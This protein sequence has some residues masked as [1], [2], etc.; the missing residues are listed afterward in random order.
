MGIVKSNIPQLILNNITGKVGGIVIRRRYGKTIIS[1]LPIS[2]KKSNSES[3]I[4]NRKR[5]AAISNISTELNKVPEFKELWTKAAKNKMSSH[6]AVSKHIAKQVRKGGIPEITSIY[7][8]NFAKLKC[9]LFSKDKSGFAINVDYS[10]TNNSPDGARKDKMLP[11]ARFIKIIALFLMKG[12]DILPA[13]YKV[14]CSGYYATDNTE[15][16]VLIKT[17]FLDSDICD[18]RDY[19]KIE[20]KYAAGLYNRYRMLINV[21][22]TYTIERY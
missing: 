3:A 17:T 5:F 7:P 13:K 1:A 14:V 22:N 15:T 6:N 12:S 10:K 8:S 20:V 9:Q 2:Y 11:N 19:E 18:M 4:N 21:S 16:E